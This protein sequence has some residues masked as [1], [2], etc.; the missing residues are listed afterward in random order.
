MGKEWNLADQGWFEITQSHK[1]LVVLASWAGKFAKLVGFSRLFV[2]VCRGWTE[3]WVKKGVGPQ[4]YSTQYLVA[5]KESRMI[6]LF[7]VAPVS[8]LTCQIHGTARDIIRSDGLCR[9]QGER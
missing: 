7:E 2:F 8:P 4:Q 9:V 3:D 6:Y 1:G 5:E